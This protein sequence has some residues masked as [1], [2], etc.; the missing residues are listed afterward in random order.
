MWDLKVAEKSIAAGR[1]IAKQSESR[2]DHLNHWPKLHS[3][4]C[5]GGGWVLR[6]R[7]QRSVLGRELGRA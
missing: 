5:L 3:L 7:L 6:L 1:R 2:T 4:R